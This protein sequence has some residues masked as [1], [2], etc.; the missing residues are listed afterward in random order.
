MSKSQQELYEQYINSPEWAEKRKLRL[1]K[2][3]Y[4]CQTCENIVR[5]ISTTYLTYPSIMSI[6]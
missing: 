5:K 1:E 3:N 2:D 6:L 4:E